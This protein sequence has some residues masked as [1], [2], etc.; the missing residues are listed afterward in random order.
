MLSLIYGTNQVAVRNYILKTSQEI[1][2]S[3]I[4]EYNISDDSVNLIETTLQ[5]DIFGDSAL[6]VIE[7]SKILKAQI[8]KLFEMLKRY[9]Q[10]NV[11]LTSTKDLEATSPLIKVVRALKGRVVPATIA[12][13]NEVFKY[14]DDLFSMRESQCYKSLQRLLE[15]DNDPVY[16]LVMLQYQLKNIALAKVGL[17]NKLPP[18]Q[19]SSVQKQSQNFSERRVLDL[20]EMLFNYDVKIK[21]G[22]IMPEVVA[23]LATQKIL[24][25]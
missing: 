12:R 2:A 4:K 11:V 9:P 10:A 15:V 6:N 8:E 5:T 3:G 14:L 1:K 16:I 20:Y 18:F 13:P 7:V 19:V 17:G 21:T 23:V 22:K 24:M 25:G